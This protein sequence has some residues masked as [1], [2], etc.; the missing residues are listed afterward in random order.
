MK[1]YSFNVNGIRSVF[2]KGFLDWIETEKPD[3]VCLQEIKADESVLDDTFRKIDGYYSYFNSAE[4][5]GYS[6]VGVYT[7]I[8]PIE[9]EDK[10]GIERFDM[11]GRS[12]KLVFDEFVLYNFYI[13]NGGRDKENF[14]YKFDAYKK[15]LKVF[16]SIK[17]EKVI[18]VGDFNIAHTELD[19]FHSKQNVNNTMFTTEERE[20]IGK[21]I[22]LGYVDTFREKYPKKEEYSWW[23]YMRN[24]RER[25]IGWRIDYVFV[26]KKLYPKVKDSFTRKDI[27]G[28]DHCPVGIEIQSKMKKDDPSYP[29][30]ILF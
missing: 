17:D 16:K 21:I 3:I 8:K 23:S 6:G 19:V 13:P 25:D 30:E 29:K 12:L 7:R 27:L 10:M 15:L 22:D 28:S 1:I 18:M 24:A 26:T 11:E 9:V 5:K 20:Q 14:S 4:K 2:S